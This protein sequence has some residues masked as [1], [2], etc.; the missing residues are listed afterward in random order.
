L[1]EDELREAFDAPQAL[2]IGIEEEVM[3]VDPVT[4]D[5]APV[6]EQVIDGDGG[7]KLELPASQAEIVVDPSVTVGE[8]IAQ[9][10]AGRRRL[11]TAAGETARVIAAGVHPHAA[12]LGALNE[13]ERYDA[14]FDAYREVA[15]SQLVCALQIHVA[16]GSADA[17]LMGGIRGDA[18]V[19]RRSQD[20]V[21][22]GSPAPHLR[23]AR[24]AGLRYAD[25]DCRSRRD[26]RVRARAGGLAHRRRRR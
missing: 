21:V 25:D 1:T 3:L 26:R 20:V 7:L 19:G 2:T 4:L 9:L 11:A 17:T 8:A 6:A 24:A 14:I 15:R 10:A 23:H 13:G 12:P 5:L 16:V 18:G 22:R